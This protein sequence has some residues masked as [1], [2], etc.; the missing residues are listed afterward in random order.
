MPR[1]WHTW[2][3]CTRSSQRCGH[4]SSTTSA[5][6]PPHPGGALA[7]NDDDWRQAL[8]TNLLAA[9]H[10]NRTLLP[11][12]LQQG[13]GVVIQITSIQRRLPLDNTLAYAAAK[14]ALTN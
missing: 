10:L 5:A 9:V 12:M 4:R 11:S 7:L 1:A 13:S 3:P 14:A 6:H 2:P 8:D